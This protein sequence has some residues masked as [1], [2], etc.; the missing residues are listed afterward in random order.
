MEV[1]SSVGGLSGLLFGV[2][3]ILLAPIQEFLFYKN[4]MKKTYLVEKSMMK[5]N[6]GKLQNH[7]LAIIEEKLK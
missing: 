4:L 5:K 7:D 2:L 1:L 6:A 3:R